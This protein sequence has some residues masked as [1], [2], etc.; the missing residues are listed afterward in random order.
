MI[1]IGNL[2]SARLRAMSL[3]GAALLTM[4]VAHPAVAQETPAAPPPQQEDIL[5]FSSGSSPALI[6]FQIT[7][8]KAADFESAWT[9]LKEAFAKVTD[10]DAKAF[11]DTLAK[12]YKLDQP[13]IET[14]GG[15]AVIYVLQLDSPSTT[16]SYN[17]V[18]IIYETLWK[19]G[20]E[21]AP[22]KREEADAIY[23]KIEGKVFQNISPWKLA[24]VG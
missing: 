9:M 4:A 20:A 21:G 6:L 22:L 14:P 19:N 2:R 10:A 23:K 13:P 11:G 16:H 15:K 1:R 17:P 18:K 24:K 7:A 5:K 8:E 3:A 12:L